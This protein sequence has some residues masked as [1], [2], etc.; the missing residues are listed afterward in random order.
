MDI[1]DPVFL[2]IAISL[3]FT[4]VNFIIAIFQ[5]FTSPYISILHNIVNFVSFTVAGIT[6]FFITLH[7]SEILILNNS[8][9]YF[10]VVI[11]VIAPILTAL[12][13]P[14]FA[15]KDPILEPTEFN[16]IR[17]QKWDKKLNKLIRF[18][19]EKMKAMM[20]KK[21]RQKENS[22][23]EDFDFENDGI[24]VEDEPSISISYNQKHNDDDTNHINLIGQFDLLKLVPIKV[25]EEIN[26]ECLSKKEKIDQE[27]R[28]NACNVW[29]KHD[30]YEDE[31]DKATNEMLESSNKLIDCN[32]YNNLSKLIHFALI[33]SSACFGQCLISGILQWQKIVGPNGSQ[34]YQRCNMFPNGTYPAFGTY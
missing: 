27:Y 26:N 21:K 34:Y 20:E 1:D 14:F 16:L 2:R 5:F 9:S 17:M 31:F 4:V 25:Q 18:K 6:A 11:V 13:V 24:L 33:V 23:D 10:F 7:T 30:I 19:V 29:C 28:L 8:I 22:I 3:A 32:A 12:I 15:K